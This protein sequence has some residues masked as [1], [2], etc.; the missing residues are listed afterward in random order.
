MLKSNVDC[1]SLVA[2][3]GIKNN[4]IESI[5]RTIGVLDWRNSKMPRG[6]RCAI[7]TY[8]TATTLYLWSSALSRFLHKA[9]DPLWTF[10]FHLMYI[11]IGKVTFSPS[12][13]VTLPD[14]NEA[15]P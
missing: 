8:M 4:V 10:A 9:A 14:R 13:F 6:A 1:D 15:C 7:V 12:M 5:D 3:V 11:S 2:C